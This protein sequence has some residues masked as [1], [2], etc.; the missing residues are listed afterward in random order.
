MIG[1]I[2]ANSLE[3][4]HLASKIA[5]EFSTDENTEVASHFPQLVWALRDVKK[6]E[7]KGN[8][9]PSANDYMEYLLS[10]DTPECRQIKECFSKRECFAFKFPLLDFEELENLEKTTE[11]QLRPAFVEE[12]N[13]LLKFIQENSHPLKM[14]GEVLTGPSFSSRLKQLLKSLLDKNLDMKN[15]FQYV[16]ED[17]NRRVFDYSI[18]SFKQ[19]LP[20]TFPGTIF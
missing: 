3:G 12:T 14:N 15:V 10:K 9:K 20:R 6:I 8:P 11:D 4:L 2:R 1:V 17:T 19:A 16:E 13:R 5:S 18:K 7:V